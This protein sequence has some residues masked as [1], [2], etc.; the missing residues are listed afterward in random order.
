MSS[1]LYPY[2]STPQ[3]PPKI[4]GGFWGTVSYMYRVQPPQTPVN[5]CDSVRDVNE[6]SKFVGGGATN[7]CHLPCTRTTQLPIIPR[8]F[9]PKKFSGNFGKLYLT[10]TEDHPQTPVNRMNMSKKNLNN[11]S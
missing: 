11:L 4:F 1:T 7:L 2:D 10:R 3:N 6:G 8:K 5:R 9:H